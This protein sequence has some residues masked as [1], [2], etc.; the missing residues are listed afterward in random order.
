MGVEMKKL[1][2]G[3]ALLVTTSVTGS[4]GIV[5]S[6]RA[7]EPPAPR[8][9]AP[10][11][12]D[13]GTA[14]ALGGAHVLGIPYDEYIRMT[15]EQWFPGMKRVKVDYPAGQ[16]Q[17]HTLE[18][19]I[20]GIGALGEQIYP[21]IGLD[22][23]SI[24]ESVDEGEGNLDAA[25][26]KGG[27]GTAMG[28]SEGALV[29]NAVKAR[30]ANDPT[31]PAPDQLTFATF[32]DP[33]A[34]HPFG[35]SFLT[36]NFPVGSVVP[37]M[38]YRIP[39]P[40]ESQY[41]TDQFISAYDSIADWPDRPDNWMSV[42]NAIAGLATGHTAIAFTN[43]S[44]VPPQNIRTTVNSKGATTTTYLVPEEHLPLVLPFKYLG[45]DQHTLNELDR[46]LQPMVDAG[47]SRN[48]DPAT[49][50]VTVDPVHGFDPA[51]VTAPANEATFGGGADPM[52]EIVNAAMSVLNPKGAG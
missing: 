4:F 27:K 9:P 39:A 14:Y 37:F 13:R 52:S 26:R 8:P 23:P 21:G 29:L 7:D 12:P 48:D 22:G 18:R 3:L 11:N 44:N 1:L 34:K 50:P 30:L 32:G 40:V 36:Q 28:L 2:A 20:P 33:I 41:H 19:F 51:E 46:V 49:A 35:E 15:G 17:G 38:D 16:V 25:I 24:G 45:Y 6:A 47:Y 10:G 31:A 43:P 42:I 5:G